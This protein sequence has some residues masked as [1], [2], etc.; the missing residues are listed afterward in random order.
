M[1]FFNRVVC[2]SEVELGSGAPSARE[3]DFGSDRF[4]EADY[5]LT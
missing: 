5:P 3:S 1:P 4:T 2:S